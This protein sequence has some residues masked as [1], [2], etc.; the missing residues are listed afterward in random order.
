M[1]ELIY[2]TGEEQDI[3]IPEGVTIPIHLIG[4]SHIHMLS[5]TLPKVFAF[6]GFVSHTAWAIGKGEDGNYIRGILPLIPEGDRVLIIFGELDCRHYVPRLA[7]ERNET[8]ESVISSIMD[9]YTNNTLRLL[10]S[11]YKVCAAGPYVCPEDL[12]HVNPWEEILEA[13]L[14][15]NDK[16][17]RFCGEQG[18]LY[19]P[20]IEEV[21]KKEWHKQ[22]QGTYF[23]DSSHLGPSIIPFILRELVGF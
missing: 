2:N 4:D 5:Y 9:L 1:P 23:N 18:I 7:K 21:I 6:H 14:L 8:I 16:L 17:K 12:S 10:H 13:K 11:R 19:I 20:I 15:F 3:P 22:P